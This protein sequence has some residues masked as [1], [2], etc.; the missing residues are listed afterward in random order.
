MASVRQRPR[1]DTRAIDST[2]TGGSSGS[3]KP[4]RGTLDVVVSRCGNTVRRCKG[5]P[6][7]TPPRQLRQKCDQIH[8]QRQLFRTACIAEMNEASDGGRF[9]FPSL[10]GLM[11]LPTRPKPARARHL[12]RLPGELMDRLI[13]DRTCQFSL[14][15]DWSAK[16]CPS[17]PP[18][19]F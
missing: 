2:S 16:Q 14:G 4:P 7:T 1:C 10:I 6:A 17:K 11:A 13:Q 19:C 8:L 9:R 3:K 12:W 18:A 15:Y 5:K